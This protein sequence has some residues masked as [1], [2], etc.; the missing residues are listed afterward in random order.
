MTSETV[1]NVVA[2]RRTLIDNGYVPIRL[3]TNQKIATEVDYLNRY[4]KDPTLALQEDGTHLNTGMLC[5]GL[6]VIDFDVDDPEPVQSLRQTATSLLGEVCLV[7][8]R[9]NSPRIA[10]VYRSSNVMMHEGITN[11]GDT[12]GR[13]LQI[14]SNGQLFIYGTHPSGVGLQWERNEGPAECHINDLEGISADQ[15][16]EFLDEACKILECEPTHRRS[17]E[18]KTSDQN[19]LSWTM[20]DIKAAFDIIPNDDTDRD[21]WR[22][23]GY[24]TWDASDGDKE[25]LDIWTDWSNKNP[26]YPNQDKECTDTWHGFHNSPPRDITPGTICHYVRTVPGSE[27]WN[28][29]SWADQIPSKAGKTAVHYRPGFVDW[30]TERAEKALIDHGIE[31]YRRAESV[32][33]PRDS[34]VKTYGGKREIIR[35]LVPV[36][37]HTLMVMLSKVSL[38]TKMTAKDKPVLINPPEEV[39]GAILA[40]DSQSKVFPFVDCI[41]YCQ[42]LRPDGTVIDK[43]GYDPAT[44][45]HIDL[46]PSIRDV[47]IPESPTDGDVKDSFALFED[48][49]GEFHFSDDY[50][51]SDSSNGVSI[52]KA[53]AF[54]MVI[55]QVNRAM[56]DNVPMNLVVG[57]E[58]GSG[59]SLLLDTVS[60]VAIGIPTP[61]LFLSRSDGLPELEKK[62]TAMICDGSPLICI[63]NL[64]IDLD[65]ELLNQMI[66]GRLFKVRSFGQNTKTIDI[67]FHGS[68]Y[69]DGN[70]VSV[71]GDGVRRTLTTKLDTKVERPELVA[72]RSNPID[73]IMADRSKYIRAAIIIPL[74][75]IKKGMPD[76]LPR[77]G[78]FG[79]WS[80]VV[81]SALVHY[82]YA[83]V[84]TSMAKAR[85]EDPIRNQQRSIIDA[86]D[87]HFSRNVKFTLRQLIDKIKSDPMLSELYNILIQLSGQ[88]A[89]TIDAERLFRVFRRLESKVFKQHDGNDYVI[90][91][92]GHKIGGAA[93]WAYSGLDIP[94]DSLMSLDAGERAS[95]VEKDRAV[96]EAPRPK[97]VPLREASD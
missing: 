43:P 24:A 67:D 41:I 81:R 56:F 95:N 84:L 30:M 23:L 47:Y 72:Y 57:P 92:T 15:V 64:T 5:R 73:K 33:L 87:D 18:R 76:K 79:L 4:Q 6:S 26:N 86:I 68:V 28:P 66:T 65:S 49:F 55:T 85:S 35:K 9:S 37:K 63:D 74:A 51:G 38:W 89:G 45:I 48:L 10:M 7:R 77:I 42:G 29:P 27:D 96:A 54:A 53:I 62:L 69:A 19:Y 61:V 40:P 70:N 25:A 88:K 59:K 3:L 97:V 78:S 58:A 52:S 39:L 11:I 94:N 36:T 2:L 71:I 32:L 80:D 75:Y 1:A 17:K 60:M 14:L 93:V 34:I 90:K 16:A 20:A 22:N 46:H 13:K 8:Y 50:G 82:G 21:K 91:R 44:N 83:D 31:I 12:D